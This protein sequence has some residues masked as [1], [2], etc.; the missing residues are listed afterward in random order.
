MAQKAFGFAD[1]R[2]NPHPMEQQTIDRVLALTG[3]DLGMVIGAPRDLSF[4]QL[5]ERE[6]DAQDGDFD[7]E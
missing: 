6:L 1:F 3:I 4:E 5:R 2:L 7:F